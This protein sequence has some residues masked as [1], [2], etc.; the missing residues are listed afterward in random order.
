MLV[1]PTCNDWVPLPGRN[2]VRGKCI[3]SVSPGGAI[4][5]GLAGR[6][7]WPAAKF[8]RN[9]KLVSSCL[10]LPRRVCLELLFYALQ[11]WSSPYLCTSYCSEFMLRS[12][13]HHINLC[14]TMPWHAVLCTT[15]M[16]D[17]G[18]VQPTMAY[19]AISRAIP[20]GLVLRASMT[21]N[22]GVL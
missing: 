2:H 9:P 8:L 11:H 17:C 4:D 5:M 14:L 10:S 20:D 18:D 1:G 22:F 15:A 13:S 12:W 3:E 6:K 7:I 21:T 16:W 19:P